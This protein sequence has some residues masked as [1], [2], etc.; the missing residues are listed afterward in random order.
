M[1][2]IRTILNIG[3]LFLCVTL[4]A[5]LRNTEEMKKEILTYDSSFKE[6]LVLRDSLQKE[7]N[8]KRADFANKDSEF[9][10]EITRIRSQKNA[11]KGKYISS[12]EEIKKR[13]IPEKKKVME[14]LLKLQG[15][16]DEQ[17]KKLKGMTKDIEEINSLLHKKDTLGLANEEMRT[18]NARLASLIEKKAVLISGND[19]IKKEIEITKLKIKVLELR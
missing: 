5:C 11:E 4:S 2:N 18:W 10:R 8:L 1:K 15:V 12:V 3:V 16:Y 19:K 7:V 13:L 17:R 14:N 9:N 6:T